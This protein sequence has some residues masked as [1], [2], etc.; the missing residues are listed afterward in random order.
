MFMLSLASLCIYII[1]VIAISRFL[2]T[3][4]ITSVISVLFYQLMFP[5]L[6]ALGPIFLL[7]KPGNFCYYTGYWEPF[8]FFPNVVEGQIFLCRVEW[9]VLFWLIDKVLADWLEVCLSSF[10][11]MGP[12]Q[13]LTRG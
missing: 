5:T 7:C 3:N 10:V 2:P 13:P 1:F 9:W 8:F 4:S 6:F 12:K 11:M